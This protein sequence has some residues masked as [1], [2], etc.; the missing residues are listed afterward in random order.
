MRT[1]RSH[2]C[3]ACCRALNGL[4]QE[5]CARVVLPGDVHHATA[6]HARGAASS[7]QVRREQQQQD[8]RAASRAH[9]R[10]RV[11]RSARRRRLSLAPR[12]EALAAQ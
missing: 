9:G 3:R 5:A 6:P 10:P 2:L 11:R 4:P 1:R 12:T 7:Q 8:E